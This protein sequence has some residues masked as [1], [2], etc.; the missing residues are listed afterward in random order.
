MFT[1]NETTFSFSHFQ[2]YEYVISP[3]IPATMDG[4]SR[5]SVLFTHNMLYVVRTWYSWY[6]YIVVYNSILYD[7]IW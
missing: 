7:E 5:H 1:F 4:M 2:T 6:T 3:N